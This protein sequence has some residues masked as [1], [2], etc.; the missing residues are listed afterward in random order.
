MKTMT[1]KQ[2]TYNYGKHDKQQ[3]HFTNNT[4]NI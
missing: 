4:N 3:N 1:N 2:I